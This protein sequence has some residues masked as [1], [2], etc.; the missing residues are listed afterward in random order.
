MLLGKIPKYAYAGGKGICKQKFA[1][2]FWFLATM[3]VRTGAALWPFENLGSNLSLLV[4]WLG[5]VLVVKLPPRAGSRTASIFRGVAQWP[6]R[7]V[8]GQ[9]VVGSNPTV[10]IPNRGVEQPG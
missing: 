6:A 10:P 2:G 4:V 9:D 3:I 5:V 1:V 8:W 7:L